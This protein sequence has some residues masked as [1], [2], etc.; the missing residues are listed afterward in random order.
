VLSGARLAFAAVFPF[1]T[2]AARPWALA[3]A[4]ISDLLDG[5]IARRFQAATWV[6]GILDAVADKAFVVAALATRIADGHLSLA[7]AALLLARDWAVLVAA[8]YGAAARRWKAFRHMP[9]RFFGK[10]TTAL[11]FP[12]FVAWYALPSATTLHEVLFWAAAASSVLAAI[13]YGRRFVL[14]IAE[15]RHGIELGHPESSAARRT[16]QARG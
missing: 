10:L 4:G 2:P 15:A 8:A 3:A 6:G 14:A 5:W 7:G 16:G 9:S 1:L 13:D 12:L 11:L